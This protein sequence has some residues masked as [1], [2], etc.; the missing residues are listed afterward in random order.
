[1][2]E[3]EY[4][5]EKIEM[6]WQQYWEEKKLFKATMDKTKKKYYCLCMLPYPSGRLHMGHVRNYSIGDV[7]AR[8]RRLMGYNVLHPIGWDS[9]GLPAE[10]AA[11]K[12]DIHPAK[13]TFSN[14][15]EMKKQL[16]SLGFSY[17]WDR[18]VATCKPEY[19]KWQQWLFIKLYEKG[20]VYRK[21]APVNWSESQ[22]TVLANEQVIN[23]RDYLTGEKVITKYLDQWFFKITDYAEQLLDDMK[24]IENGWPEKV[25]TM[26]KNWIGR[27]YGV[28][29]NFKFEGQ[30][31]P[32]FTTRP[33]TIYGVTYMA[34]AAEHHLIPEII[35][36]APNKSEIESFIN[37][38]KEESLEERV[39]EEGEKKGIF[40][41]KYVINP[42]NNEKIPLYV[43][44][45]V[46]LGYGY[47][48]IMAVP[49]HDQRDFM[50]AKKYDISI[51]IVIQN[52]DKS[53]KIENM[54]EAYIGEGTL[55][56][57]EPFNGM[58][59]NKAIDKIIEYSEKEGFGK[60]TINYRLR[61]WLISRQR[62]WGNPI[63][64]IY[65]GNGD[66]SPEK[67]E[68]LP[69]ELPLDVKF[70]KGGNPLTTSE[71]FKNTVC[72]ETNKKG[73]RE[74]D[75]MDTFVCSSWY[76]LRYTSP[77]EDNAPFNKEEANY[78]M[79]IDQYIGGIEHAT[80]HLI[81]ARF[82]TKALRDLGLINLTE[83][84][85]NLL[86]QGM[87]TKESYYSS[88][89]KKYYFEHE[90]PLTEQG[91]IK[92]VSPNTDEKLIVKVEK[93]S[94]SK[95]NGIDPEK[96]INKY[97]A[98]TVRL[99]CLFASPPE[100]ELEWSDDGVD[101]SHRFL[102]R[103]YR[104]ITKYT[105][106]VKNA[107]YDDIDKIELTKDAVKL[108]NKTHKTIKK[109]TEDFVERYHFN[110]GIAM[111][112]E[113]VNQIYQFNPDSEADYKVLKESFVALTRLLFPI[114][115]HVAEELHREI[116]YN[117]SIYNYKWLE[118]IEELTKDD[119]VEYVFQ[120]N[121]KIRGKE[122]MPVG[123]SKEEL[124]KIALENEKVTKWI[125][126]KKIVKVIVVPNKLVNI[127]VKI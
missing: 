25:L 55:V 62:Y 59:S 92:A 2:T 44:N 95:N 126:N 67:E 53:L 96:L 124:E 61:D 101:G 91:K 36:D 104:I 19:Y 63:P 87:V 68:N 40:T 121:G 38:V 39:S 48:A 108:R 16:M 76:F 17:D 32:I 102:N 64:M 6:K 75:T 56:N 18:E 113:L 99:F 7:I 97:G 26:Q 8:T 14:I 86:T 123:V 54:T 50:F 65:C 110:T 117:G 119:T 24:L 127:V 35:K 78:W 9:F 29:I 88:S 73:K 106:K 85:K 34:I 46:L 10:Q 49:G 47:G 122:K 28:N 5:F 77:N 33:D 111:L 60:R 116:G 12:R 58:N 3:R 51:K 52:A 42:F 93:M 100:K 89:E 103:V 82:F 69:V 72:S 112:M 114:C 107:N 80:G 90:L 79:P 118:Y 115:P 125:E 13:W 15:E 41:G 98:D 109:C 20:L 22:Q 23:G 37:E 74:T 70:T 94:K 27:S 66:I 30:D 81:Y 105:D 45:F 43:A 21:K 57:S 84:A 4:D 31:F 1:M 120:V 71:T 83:P 11:M